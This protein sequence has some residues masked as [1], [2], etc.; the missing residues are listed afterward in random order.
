MRGRSKREG[1]MFLTGQVYK[2]SSLKNR[3]YMKATSFISI[4]LILLLLAGCSQGSSV[5]DDPK[6]EC[7]RVG[8]Q[9]KTF[10]NACADTCA[11]NRGESDICAQVLTE[12]CDCGLNKC[13]DGTTCKII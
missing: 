5:L 13:W 10:A 4:V 2:V 8:K 6:A 11:Y 1:Y 9:W 3:N 7:L 12:S